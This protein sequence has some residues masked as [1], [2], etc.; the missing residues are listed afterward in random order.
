MTDKERLIELLEG[1]SGGYAVDGLDII[2]GGAE[3]A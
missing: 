1:I 2:E 3:N